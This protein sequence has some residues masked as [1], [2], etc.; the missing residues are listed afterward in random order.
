M[1]HTFA[2]LSVSERTYR[3]IE[4]KLRAADYHHVFQEGAIDMHG[5]GLVI[6]PD[7]LGNAGPPVCSQCGVVLPAPGHGY[8]GL[9]C[10]DEPKGRMERT[11]ALDKHWEGQFWCHT[12]E[13]YSGQPNVHQGHD[14]VQ[15]PIQRSIDG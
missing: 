7:D 5:I 4:Q 1:T 8:L 13:F 11:A 9:Y 10:P 2:R 12:C 15:I 6:D 14:L 3:E